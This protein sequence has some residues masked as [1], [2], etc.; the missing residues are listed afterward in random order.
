MNPALLREVVAAG[1]DGPTGDNCQPW[2]IALG[3]SGFDLFFVPTPSFFDFRDLASWLACGCF[4][5]NVRLAAAWRG[6]VATWT[7]SPDPSQPLLWARVHLVP[8]PDLAP[9]ELAEAIPTRHANR[10]PFATSALSDAE[11]DA[12]EAEANA[13]SRVA[14]QRTPAAMVRL[15][16]LVAYGEQV[17]AGCRPAHESTSP[18]F[19]WTRAHA[20]QTRDGLDSRVLGAG[21]LQ[22][23]TLRLLQPWSR[24]RL[25]LGVGAGRVMGRY[26]GELVRCSGGV[27][28]VAAR[29]PGPHGALYAGLALERAWLRATRLGLGFSVLA[30][31][32]LFALRVES[33]IC[34][35]FSPSECQGLREAGAGLRE[36]FGLDASDQPLVLFRVG[37]GPGQQIVS[38]RRPV[39]SFLMPRDLPAVSPPG[40][41]SARP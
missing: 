41:T 13:V 4:L 23:L 37:R 20:E 40:E 29:R 26:A 36:I 31:L 33:G 30:A 11:A 12:L 27:G 19:R 21:P 15:R 16:E 17:R 7:P 39:D 38:L 8:A 22:R 25:A 35:G 6:L 1:L 28:V 9:D 32:P 34:D 14:I 18:W 3:P 10:E 24:M 5:E 2:R